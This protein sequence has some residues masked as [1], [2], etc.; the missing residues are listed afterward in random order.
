[1]PLSFS[2]LVLRLLTHRLEEEE[3]E[4]EEGKWKVHTE[5]GLGLLLI[6]RSNLN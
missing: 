2:L 4:E 5:Q 1:V 3:E 6:Q